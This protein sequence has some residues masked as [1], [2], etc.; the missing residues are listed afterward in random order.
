MISLFEKNLMRMK[1]EL[2]DIKTVHD[3]GLGTVKF[4]R[5]RITQPHTVSQTRIQYFKADI[6]DGEPEHPF[7]EGM[8]RSSTGT[9]T[10]ACYSADSGST[11]ITIAFECWSGPQTLTYDIISSSVLKNLRFDHEESI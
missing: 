11:T 9:F 7:I 2:R 10:S 1:N 5:Y 3:R 6:A 4:F 8:S